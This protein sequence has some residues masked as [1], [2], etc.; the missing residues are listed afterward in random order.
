[1]ESL[2]GRCPGLHQ[3]SAVTLRVVNGANPLFLLCLQQAHSKSSGCSDD[4][5]V[6]APTWLQD[7]EWEAVKRRR[8]SHGQATLQLTT[9]AEGGQDSQGQMVPVLWQ[10]P[11]AGSEQPASDGLCC[12]KPASK[13]DLPYLSTRGQRA[14]LAALMAHSCSS[15]SCRHCPEPRA[16]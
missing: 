8:W 7:L 2:D 4:S 12:A 10:R 11:K 1:M 9:S 14:A 3:C 13:L 15:C 16:R 5:L 6:P